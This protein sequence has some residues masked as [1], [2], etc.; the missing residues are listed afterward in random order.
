MK[1][2][3]GA[4]RRLQGKAPAG[5]RK[6]PTRT[7]VSLLPLALVACVA[8]DEAPIHYEGPLAAQGTPVALRQAVALAHV[9]LTPMRVVEDSRC[10]IDARCVW[11]GRIVVET[12]VDGPGWRETLQFQPGEPQ[13]VRDLSIALVS[14]EPARPS[15]ESAPESSRYRFTFALAD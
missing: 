2:I 4:M 14:V 8:V 10:P 9:A 11:P 13:V 1:Y 12:R 7:I 6:V 3:R 15:A 5:K